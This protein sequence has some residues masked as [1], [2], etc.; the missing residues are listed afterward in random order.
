MMTS[1][2][3]RITWVFKNYI[4][5]L[6]IQTTEPV[7]TEYRYNWKMWINEEWKFGSQSLF[8][9]TRDDFDFL[10]HYLRVLLHSCLPSPT[11]RKM[12]IHVL[13]VVKY[14]MLRPEMKCYEQ[15]LLQEFSAHVLHFRI[16]SWITPTDCRF[17]ILNG[18]DRNFLSFLRQHPL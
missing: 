10:L 12:Q 18:P 15:G 7:H 6:R 17:W 8:R 13:S 11:H 5:L 14:Q 1:P 16:C 9:S 2:I 3:K 4:L